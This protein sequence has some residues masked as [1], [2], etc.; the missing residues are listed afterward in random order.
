MIPSRNS[1]ALAI[2]TALIT[3][4]I[5]PRRV[6]LEITSLKKPTSSGMIPLTMTRPT[7]VSTIRFWIVPS[8]K[9]STTTLIKA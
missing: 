4:E 6:F 1:Q 8:T 2:P 3:L 5:K 7:E 9:S